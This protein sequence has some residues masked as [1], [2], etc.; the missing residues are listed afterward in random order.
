[1]K[2]LVFA[3]ALLATVASATPLVRGAN[4][5]LDLDRR[6]SIKTGL[7][8]QGWSMVAPQSIDRKDLGKGFRLDCG[9]AG[10]VTGNVSCE[11]LSASSV[12]VRY[13]FHSDAELPIETLFVSFNPAGTLLS[14]GGT[15]S[16]DGG[17]PR[18][19]PSALGKNYLAGVQ[20]KRLDI[21]FPAFARKPGLRVEFD[22]PVHLDVS[23]DRQWNNAFSFRVPAAP[24]AKVLAKGDDYSLSFVLST[25]DGSSLDAVD[26]GPD[27]IEAREGEWVALPAALDVAPGS[28]L[29]FSGIAP[30][31]ADAPAGAHGRVIA[32]PDGHFA[33]EDSP[34]VPRRFYGPNTCFSANFLS[35]DEAEEIALRFR[36]IGYNSV[37]IHHYD[38][39]WCLTRGAADGTTPNPDQ[40]AALD[41]TAAVFLR[42]G[43]YLT[44]D[45]YA[46]RA[47]PYRD[48]GI[49]RDGKTSL[50]EFKLLC[51]VSPA[52]RDNWKRFVRAVLTHVNPHTGRPY[53]EEPGLAWLC[54]VNEGNPA[55]SLD[56]HRKI[57]AFAERWKSWLDAKKAAD[58]A[59]ADI[60]DTIPDAL[61]GKSIHAA[62][63]AQFLDD[64]EADMVRDLSAFVRDELGCRALLT[65]S[66]GW[67]TPLPNLRYRAQTLDYVDE[68]FYIDHPKMYGNGWNPPS[69][70]D[71]DDPFFN[72]ER[73]ITYVLYNRV[74]GKPFTVSEYNYCFPGRNRGAGGMVLGAMAALQ[75]W[76]A[77]WRF[78]F[79]DKRDVLFTPDIARYM[80]IGSDPAALA[81]ERAAVALFLRRDFEPLPDVLA[82]RLPAEA[83]SADLRPGAPGADPQHWKHAA[84]DARAGVAIGTEPPAGGRIFAYDGAFPAACPPEF[85]ETRMP[86]GG[87]DTRTE[88]RPGLTASVALISLDGEPL[89]TS[90]HILVLHIPEVQNT[91]TTFADKAHRT[92]TKWGELPHL[93]RVDRARIDLPGDASAATV[94]ALFMD[95]TRGERIP[96]ENGVFLADSSR[97]TLYYEVVR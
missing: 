84:W 18:A 45:L 76:S 47:I 89:R 56:G 28:A 7:F 30:G 21:V 1:M 43:L 22:A 8:K 73:G 27:A 54:L 46:W 68:H 6:C 57:P 38:N 23:D 49:D 25:S 52:A 85:L 40:F 67:R 5:T 82:L 17:E 58:S 44:L 37:R 64:L 61:G 80:N 75:D 36:R 42:H 72:R 55:N 81:S 65:N 12:R 3:V 62:A 94:Y 53:A 14:D 50:D 13:E 86:L 70:L 59:Y 10:S 66:N 90:R 92:L 11:A 24:D 39:E 74:F 15:W 78:T 93:V 77:V 63:Y 4:G 19:F 91:G 16:V 9:P 29:D 71:G 33:F 69:G 88:I 32:T 87:P 41:A 83:A 95:G 60:P 26:D 79:A 2:S 31:T 97:A 96:V 20:A 35:P 34:R 48:L 51:L